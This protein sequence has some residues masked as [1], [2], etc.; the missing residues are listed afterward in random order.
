MPGGPH[1]QPPPQPLAPTTRS[2]R[3]RCQRWKLRDAGFWQCSKPARAGF[4]VCGY[5]GAGL[6]HRE[7]TGERKHVVS[8]RLVTGAHLRPEMRAQLF[9]TP[10]LGELMRQQLTTD[11]LDFREELATARAAWRHYTGT[12]ALADDPTLEARLDALYRG[13]TRCVELGERIAALEDRAGPMRRAD[14][15]EFA[16]RVSAVIRQ[17]IPPERQPDAWA[18]LG[19][20]TGRLGLP[21]P[22]GD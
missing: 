4:P 13:L 8:G 3:P 12:R 2:G 21:A 10:Q 5:H 7:A 15:E 19:V 6:A 17:F 16:T 11:L 1:K 20:V 18:L 22:A 14:L 9:K